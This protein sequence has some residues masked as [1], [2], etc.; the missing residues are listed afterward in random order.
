MKFTARVVAM[1]E[2]SQLT[3]E[4]QVIA[5]TQGGASCSISY[6]CEADDA[7]KL[8]ELIDIEITRVP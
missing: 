2:V 5:Q 8:G 3:H 1:E 6:V 7:P 4:V